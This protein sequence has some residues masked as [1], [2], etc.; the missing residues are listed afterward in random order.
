MHSVNSNFFKNFIGLSTKKRF[1]KNLGQK[2][3]QV[4]VNLGDDSDVVPAFAVKVQLNVVE[5]SPGSLVCRS[6]DV[7]SAAGGQRNILEQ[8]Q[9]NVRRDVKFIERRFSWLT[10]FTDG[11]Q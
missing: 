2:I 4:K 11:W 9:R 3:I 1:T 10:E 7:A 5:P 8:Q 6:L